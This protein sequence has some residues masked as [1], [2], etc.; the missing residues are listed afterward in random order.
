MAKNK[1]QEVRLRILDQCFRK[2][3][4]DYTLENL[5]EAC[6]DAMK[7]KYN[8]SVSRR[9]IQGDINFMRDS[10]GYNAPIV[11][12]ER[13][14][15]RHVYYYSDPNFSI[16]NTPLQQ[17][18]VNKLKTALQMLSGFATLPQFEWM[19]NLLVNLE[20]KL[21]MRGNTSCVIGLEQ[22]VDYSATKLISPLFDAIVGRQ[23]LLI[24][25]RPFSGNDHYW[26]IHPYFLKQYNNR[27]F[28][29][30]RQGKGNGRLM[31]LALDRIVDWKPTDAK[32][33]DNDLVNIDDYFDEIVGVTNNPR[34]LE[35]KVV[36]KFEEN[37]FRYVETK[38]IHGSMKVINREDHI[39]ELHLK[40]N[41]ELE[42]L[43]LSYGEKV[44]V[45]EPKWLRIRIKE[46]LKQAL[47]HYTEEE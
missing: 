8:C 45:L 7:E 29:L 22:N 19:Q 34:Q 13:Y 20:D 33:L 4:R 44:E 9:T 15:K 38:P 27:W 42:S 26:T 41:K 5:I 10:Q 6:N 32:Y 12:E 3:S 46:L 1:H 39:V 16:F 43:L 25:Y 24:H 40:T 2:K 47:D 14:G 31:V 23:V 11:S 17:D 35:C 37:W 30:G 28:L 18:E 36:L 21:G